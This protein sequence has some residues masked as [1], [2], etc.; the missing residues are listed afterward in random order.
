MANSRE[1][2]D[3]AANFTRLLEFLYDTD[4]ANLEEIRELLSDHGIDPNELL[5]DGLK[6][7]RSLEKGEKV[8]IAQEKRSR[9]EKVFKGLKSIDVAQPIEEVRKKISEILK[10]EV[11]S[12]TALAFYHKYES[13]S[14]EDL[15]AL[16][17]DAVLLT[18]LEEELKALDNPSDE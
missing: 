18:K 1:S 6:Y 14:D 10:G 12:Q 16:L 9:L 2:K 13:L 5:S 3:H 8:K 11:D 4:E 17:A 7:I 15:R